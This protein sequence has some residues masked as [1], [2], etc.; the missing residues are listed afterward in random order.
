MVHFWK[1]GNMEVFFLELFSHIDKNSGE[2]SEDMF[3]VKIEG[4]SL[5]PT[6]IQKENSRND[7]LTKNNGKFRLK[8]MINRLTHGDMSF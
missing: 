2:K 5:R 8:K 4:A 1:V 3:V 6:K 7:V